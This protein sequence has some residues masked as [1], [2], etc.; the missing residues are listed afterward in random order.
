M[1]SICLVVS[2]LS[3]NVRLSEKN[4]LVVLKMMLSH[5]VF[6]KTIQCTT[7]GGLFKVPVGLANPRYKRRRVSP[8]K[9]DI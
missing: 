8:V 5:F 7:A 3:S 6:S 1:V 2:I 9:L 4:D